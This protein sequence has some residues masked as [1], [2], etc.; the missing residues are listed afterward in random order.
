MRPT[1]QAEGLKE[2]LLQY[3][4]T[5]YALSDEG[6]REALHR[7]LGDETS[8]MFRGPFLRLRTPFT[9]ADSGWEE[10]L[11]WR[12]DDDWTPYRH[13]ARAF[14]RL[15]SAGGR[16]PR[17][18][19]LTTGTGSG[20]TEAFLYPVLDHCAR[21]RAAGRGGVKA[22]LLYPM[23][24]LATDQAGRI[25]KLLRA[26]R[27]LD[28]VRA[29]LY[30]GDDPG[31]SYERV[32]TR[33]T[34]MWESPPDL[35]IT[36]YKM[37]D[38]LLQRESDTALWEGADLRYVVVDEFHTYDGAQGTDVAILLR[39][40]AAA[41]GTPEPGRPLGGICPVATSATLSSGTDTLDTEALLAS[42]EQVFGTEF[43][44]DSVIGEDRQSVAEFAPAVEFD[45]NLP[46]PRPDEIAALGDPSRSEEAFADLVEAVTGERD[47]DPFRLGATLKRHTLTAA[48]LQALEGRIDTLP[49]AL[50]LVWRNGAGFWARAITQE[51]DKA[52]IALSRFVALLSAARDP[53]STEKEPRPLVQVEVHQWAR[54]VSRLVRGVLPWPKA[55]FRWD[56]A[57]RPSGHET[58]DAPATTNTASKSANLFL[59]AVYCRS[60]GRSGWAAFSP[61]SDE[62]EVLFDGDKIW[63]ASTGQD[64]VRVRALIA[65]SDQ[66]AGEG[67]GRAPMRRSGRV[68]GSGSNIGGQLRVLDGSAY[69]L[70]LPDPTQDYDSATGEPRLSTPDSAFVL[71]HLGERA[72]VAAADDQCPGCGERYAIR[73]LGTGTAAL[74]AA[75]ITQLFTGG[76]LDKN[77]TLMF[78]GSVQDAAHRS[79]FVASRSYTFSLR[80]LFTKYL[81]EEGPTALNDLIANVVEATTDPETLAAVVPTD[82]HDIEGVKRLLSGQGR[83]GD[84]RTWRLIGERFAFEALME[85]GLRSRNGRTLELTRTA[86]AN[87]R[88]PDPAAAADL[89][90]HAHQKAVN[91]G[92]LPEVAQDDARYLGFLRVFLERVR[93]RGG[94]GHRWLRDHMGEVGAT[95]YHIWGRRPLGMRAFPKGLTAPRFLLDRKPGGRTE[96]DVVT[97]TGGWFEAWTGKCL[98]LPRSD[99]EVFW[100]SLLP[101][102]VDA[103]L[104]STLSAKA[105]SVL[106]HGLNPGAVEARL[107]DDEDVD[108]AFVRCPSCLWEQTVHP[109]L[110]D[111][112]H[113]LPCPAYRCKGY[114]LVAGDRRAERD[115]HMRDRDYGDDYY[116]RLYRA[117]G[118]Y[119]V[120]TAEHTGMLTRP[121]REG[122]E[123]AFK[124]RKGFKDPNVLSCTPTLEMGIDIGDLS[125]V[126]LAALPRGSANYLQQVGRAGR[127]TGNAFLLTI[128]GRGRRDLYY[129]EQPKEMIDGRITPPGSYLSAVEILRR[130]YLA[131]LL[132][133][134]ARGRLTRADGVP[135]PALPAKAPAL[136]GPSG[137]LTDLVEA[138]LADADRLTDGF[139]S[140][141]PTGVEERSREELRTYARRGLRGAVEEAER[142]WRRQ[143][144]ALRRRLRLIGEAG[145]ELAE[146]DEEERGTGAE[147]EAERRATGRRLR[148]LGTTSAQQA[149]CDLGLLPNYA[150]VDTSTTLNATLYWEREG[151]DAASGDE[152]RPGERQPRSFGSEV[153]S[154]DRPRR[155]AISELAPGNTFYV[156]GYK[157][158]VTGLELGGS[159]GEQWRYW[160]FCQECGYVRVDDARRD[161]RPCPRCGD[162]ALADDGSSLFKVVEP[163][164][165][166]SRDKREDA[167]INDDN[168]ERE[169][170]HYA[171]VDAVDIPTEAIEP[172]TSWR[173]T[174]QTFGVDFCRTAMIR[175][176]NVGPER[177]D[178][179][180]TDTFVG[181]NVRLAPFHVCSQCGAA[182]VDDATVPPEGTGSMLGAKRAPYGHHEPWCRLRRG[183]DR[184]SQV[185]QEPVL[186][187][188]Q[189][190]TEAL[191]VLL[192]AA[193]ALVEEKVHS[194]RA[195]LR[196]GVDRYFGGDPQHLDSVLVSMR[197]QDAV[198][199]RHYLVLFDSLPGGTGYLHRLTD[200]GTF[201]EIL[202]EARR[203]LVECPCRGEGRKACHRCLYRYTEDHRQDLVERR[204][205]LEI[206]NDLLGPIDENGAP[207]LGQDGREIDLWQVRNLPS[208]DR[209]GLDRQVESDLE[210]RFLSTLRRAV[211]EAERASW[212]EEG[213]N[214]G[215]LR[216]REEE[217]TRWRL[218][219]QREMEY[220][221]T[222]F[223]FERVDGPKQ[224]VT[225]YL[226]GHRFHA[227]SKH[228]RIAA[229]GLK[230][231]RLRAEGHLVFQITWDDLDLF[232]GKGAARTEPV[233]RPESGNEMEVA[234]DI[235]EN[236]G[237]SRSA[238]EEAV[239]A[240]PMDTLLAYLREPD[241][242][243][244]GRRVQAMVAGTLAGGALPL[245]QGVAR[246]TARGV[247]ESAL[248]ARAKGLKPAESTSP[249]ASGED[250]PIM[251]LH[252][253]DE[254]GF[255][256]LQAFDLR[257][258]QDL[259][260]TRW[261]VLV[262]LDDTNEALR[263]DGH[264][265]S[266]H[267]WLY[268]SNLLQFLAYVGGD[269]AQL[270][271][272]GA[273]DFPVEV[274]T[275]LGGAGELDS[276][277]AESG[278]V[279][280]AMVV[281]A[282]PTEGAEHGP[283]WGVRPFDDS[284]REEARWLRDQAWYTQVINFL[285]EDEPN[286]T[287][288]RLA[289]ELAE[290]GKKAPLY[291]FELGEG[292]WMVDF[293]WE[294][295]GK[296]IAVVRD[297]DDVI[298]QEGSD[299]ELAKRDAVYIEADWILR[300][301]SQWFDDLDFLLTLLPET[302]P[303]D[304]EGLTEQ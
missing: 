126:V 118:T 150:L 269:G 68:N 276:I 157:H 107:L 28:G 164:I 278:V 5:T 101:A 175:R 211:G 239:Y 174:S 221:R 67:S 163:T 49:E 158:R 259:G 18:T 103:G 87:V 122:V 206:L 214:S 73:F 104:L 153:R 88:V 244:W 234:K 172:D 133:L 60:C 177:T 247:V 210:A 231:N 63:R 246:D 80:A 186:L 112:W 24:A 96:F 179:Q 134:A 203:A 99:N 114:R 53:E 37:L 119:Q 273:K 35:L 258:D 281:V 115:V 89:V 250:A 27:E 201:R 50:D 46:Q 270:A 70:R 113:D 209:I 100:R 292:A 182:S 145:R 216:F 20:K 69:R 299:E 223:T 253:T 264:K 17:P 240:N 161:K 108:T 21:E 236:L 219:A 34:Q 198:A 294:Y 213:P 130:Q 222:D 245:A 248:V 25:E 156:N 124:D 10:L 193:T 279:E 261:S 298:A 59:P 76:E 123:R 275:V 183:R 220:T 41:V 296:K 120:V 47:T 94:I 2:S 71:V 284:S 13:Q 15:S 280:R 285:E 168:N 79:G 111:Q 58:R 117:A 266:W 257:E 191:R 242:G 129:L 293:A 136:F 92:S 302:E 110:L 109:S 36:N 137:Y 33:R 241:N 8:G 194:L 30:V 149:M 65:A 131:H 23:N 252:R 171:V 283:A 62:A 169:Q 160:R 204:I 132:D 38:L 272:S 303:S 78:N 255:C 54:A 237:G 52:V 102:L 142:Q 271:A 125:A 207:L 263:E 282:D 224:S 147:L 121:Q 86:A 55:E 48:V 295:K 167:R 135:I 91:Q 39:R 228:N 138:A 3:L 82:L 288:T 152:G 64:K 154:Y 44:E 260:K 85:F 151:A 291:G 229:D 166:T 226:D 180:N 304:L 212:D 12:R 155:Y 148:A 45:P 227:T 187:A 243:L 77:K 290:R 199:R 189:L 95:R 217:T 61:E 127:R 7:F 139:L 267:T 262:I 238:L 141:F 190:R 40:L 31:T 11:D 208:T 51:Q 233:W 29:G 205:A 188:H 184:A 218:T 249:A 22:V 195:A 173:H 16:T 225:V 6:A 90:R 287:L 230:R 159:D 43:T 192:P 14:E 57:G 268:W 75:S 232:E 286:S 143:E 165:V 19:L 74:A 4:S 170:R 98:E 196:L 56:A 297:E 254:S 265:R 202:V 301:A 97:G 1:L 93:T 83:G 66:Q 81:S 84:L 200:P 300:T 140:L 256:L 128:P 32:Y 215:Y 144:N 105:G 42:A 274:L 72:N 26:Y 146:G 9:R 116:R 277:A 178:T 162:I 181:K 176:I 185:P 251:V 235:Y 289:K 106:V 197:D